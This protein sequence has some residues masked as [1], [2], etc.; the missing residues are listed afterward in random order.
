MQINK[1]YI[2]QFGKIERKEIA[3]RP[4]INII[5]GEN[6]SGKSTLEHFI[7]TMFYGH[8]TSKKYGIDARMKYIPFGKDF[9]LGRL[10]FEKDKKSYVIERKIGQKRKDDFFRSYEESTYD[11]ASFD[12]N[13]GKV[14]FDLDLEPFLKTLFITQNGSKFFPEND[15]SLN[16]KLTNLLETGDEEVSFTKA[17]DTIDKEM[18]LIK[19][20]R[21][22]G[23]L[24]ELYEKL[25][26]SYKRLEAARIC[27]EKTDQIDKNLDILENK[28]TSLETK[29]EKISHLKGQ[30]HLYGVQGEVFQIFKNL[31]SIQVIKKDHQTGKGVIGPHELQSFRELLEERVELGDVI[32][33][34]SEKLLKCSRKLISL[35]MEREP[36]RGYAELPTNIALTLVHMQG[37]EKLISEKL[38]QFDTNNLYSSGFFEKQEE[39]KKLLHQYEVHL[40][41]LRPLK[42]RFILGVLSGLIALVLFASLYKNGWYGVIGAIFLCITVLLVKPFNLKRKSN[43]LLK[44][45]KI[46]GKISALALALEMDPMEVIKAKRLIDKLPKKRELIELENQLEKIQAGAQDYFRTTGTQNLESFIHDQEIFKTIDTQYK[47]LFQEQIILEKEFAIQKEKD[48][49][50]WDKLLKRLVIYGYDKE[51][52]EPDEFLDGYE[53]K[54]LRE[55]DLLSQEDSFTYSLKSLIGDKSEEQF[56]E[57]IEIMNQMGLTKELNLSQVQEIEEKCSCEADDLREE[58]TKLTKE[59][60]ILLGEEPLPIEDEISILLEEEIR[61]KRRYLVLQTTKELMLASYDELREKFIEE[62]NQNVSTIFK[63]ITKSSRTVK[64]AECFSMNLEEENRIR[65][66]DYLSKGSL[67]QLYFSLRLAMIDLIFQGETVP[68][69]LDEPFASYDG[70]RLHTVLNYLIK[71]AD[72][73]QIFIFTC[74][75]REMAILKD[76]GHIIRL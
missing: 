56:M 23:T 3:F 45:E 53:H 51:Q 22:V 74:H 39:L 6:E 11:Q 61:L 41:K 1:V 16:T 75:E 46:E 62:L 57:E 19:G 71:R 20:P 66:E 68:I 29:R 7:L 60:G 4:G 31:K 48:A 50:S 17:M 55:L 54:M 9:S 72:K 2:E 21:K 35:A 12:E 18:R 14:L 10:I 59:K 58:I 64:V 25:R 47:I 38:K 13:L 73:Y 42:K 28:L 36:Y 24:D 32:E 65:P 49:Q 5:Y 44:I 67:D 76:F 70:Y 37:E 15:E 69:F 30:L 26:V 27:Q 8:K 40:K 43:L 33:E 34:I 63:T 52:Y